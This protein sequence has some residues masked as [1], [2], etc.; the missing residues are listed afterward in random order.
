M[1][2][3]LHKFRQATSTGA[4]PATYEHKTT[5]ENLTEFFEKRN[6]KTVSPWTKMRPNSPTSCQPE[7]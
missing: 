7:N 3:A 2:T 1:T 6:I 5:R 4:N